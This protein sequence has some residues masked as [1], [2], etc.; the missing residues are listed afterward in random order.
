MRNDLGISISD[1]KLFFIFFPSWTLCFVLITERIVLTYYYPLYATSYCILHWSN[2]IIR[3][4]W[5]DRSVY[6]II[7]PSFRSR[8][9]SSLILVIGSYHD[10][11]WLTVICDTITECEY[12]SIELKRYL[13]WPFPSAYLEV[14]PTRTE[15]AR[16]DS[17]L[18]ANTFSHVTLH[19]RLAYLE[20]TKTLLL[21]TQVFGLVCFS[22]VFSY[23]K[24]KSEF[25]R[26]QNTPENGGCTKNTP[27]VKRV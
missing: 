27:E 9:G 13:F 3:S 14:L 25:A 23:H 12:V 17:K 18:I 20:S 15:Y 5:Y 22:C 2:F 8:I 7:P 24:K 26:G 16:I 10:H 4:F 6:H 19:H 11:W 1:L 21:F